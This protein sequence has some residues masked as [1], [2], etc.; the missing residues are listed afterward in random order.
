MLSVL[1]ATATDVQR[2][3]SNAGAVFRQ[4]PDMLPVT[5]RVDKRAVSQ[6]IN[7]AF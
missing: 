2:L 3:T 5:G 7:T 6:I 1:D 4:A